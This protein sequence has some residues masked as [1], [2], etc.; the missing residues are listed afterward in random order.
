VSAIVAEILLSGQ[1]LKVEL[2]QSLYVKKVQQ[3]SVKAV[4]K[5][6]KQ[7]DE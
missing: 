3:S 5:K 1:S 4:I 6:L 7:N 2:K